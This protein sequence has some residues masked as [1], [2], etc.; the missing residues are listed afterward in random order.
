MQNKQTIAREA[1]SLALSSPNDVTTMLTRS[2]K[3]Q[4]ENKELGKTQHET[5]TKPHNKQE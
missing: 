5:A 2:E 4:H 3:Q 1:H